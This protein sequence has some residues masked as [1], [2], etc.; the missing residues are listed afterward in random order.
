MTSSIDYIT[1]AHD[2]SCIYFLI[3]YTNDK[4][5]VTSSDVVNK[6]QN[7]IIGFNTDILLLETPYI[8]FQLN[9][10]E[11]SIEGFHIGPVLKETLTRFA[12][13]QTRKSGLRIFSLGTSQEIITDQFPFFP[14]LPPPTFS[15]L[16]STLCPSQR[17]LVFGGVTDPRIAGNIYININFM[18][19]I[20]FI[21]LINYFL[22]IFYIVL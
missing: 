3:S 13:I 19:F 16:I 17:V 15:S 8:T 14:N 11:D 6:T 10:K 12:F 21:S 1:P 20:Q 9:D 2:G 22:M 4:R 18:F 7:S 5:N